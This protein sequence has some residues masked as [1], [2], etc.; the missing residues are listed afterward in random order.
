MA[1]S[2]PSTAEAA[3]AHDRLL[4][5][6]GALAASVTRH[7]LDPRFFGL[8]DEAD[9]RLVTALGTLALRQPDRPGNPGLVGGRRPAAEDGPNAAGR[10]SSPRHRLTAPA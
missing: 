4:D 3:N 9:L 1:S 5:L 2:G 6:V 7:I 8:L 10:R